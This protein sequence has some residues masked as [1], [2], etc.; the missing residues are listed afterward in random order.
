MFFMNKTV[1]VV[2]LQPEYQQ[3]RLERRVCLNY[4]VSRDSLARHSYAFRTFDWSY[5]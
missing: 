3:S 1:Q 2:F 5:M 4:P